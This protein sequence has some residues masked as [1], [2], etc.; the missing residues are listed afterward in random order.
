[1]TKNCVW[2]NTGEP[3][4]YGNCKTDGAKNDSC[5]SGSEKTN[6]LGR[7]VFVLGGPG[8][9]KGTQCARLVE[10]YGFKH[11]SAGDLLRAEVASG[12]EHGK[13]LDEWMKE[14]KIVPGSITVTLI[15]NAMTDAK[16]IYLIDGFPREMQQGLEFER[17][18]AKCE[19]VLFFDC[20]ETVMEQRL[21][22][23]GETSGRVD[24]NAE[25]IKK[26]FKTFLE[27][28][29]PVVEHFEKEGR[30]RKVSADA[31]ADDIYAEVQKIFTEA[32][33]V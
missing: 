11:L 1:M 30:V 7:V 29:L 9:G 6:G 20:S 4:K 16:A 14:G 28:S 3:C 15:K 32:G 26:R 23:R 12:S 2:C 25:T 10:Q 5:P 22:K 27:Q 18:V 17:D 33:L 8:S 24:D 31:A 21:I 19:F 13:Q